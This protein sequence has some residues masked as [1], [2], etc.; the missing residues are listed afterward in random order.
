MEDDVIPQYYYAH[1]NSN[2]EIHKLLD[3]IKLKIKKIK[4]KF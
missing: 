1:L 3:G 2:I 4:F